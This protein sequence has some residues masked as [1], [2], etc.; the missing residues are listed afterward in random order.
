MPK[1]SE[2]TQALRRNRILDA[3]ERCFVR[4][5][6]NGATMQDIRREAGVSAG[7][8][9]VYFR[10]K[11]D[12]I[13]GISQRDR[14]QVRDNVALVAA[15]DD[16]VEGLAS[17][18]R[19]SAIERPLDKVRLFIE[20][21]AQ[22]N[23]SPAVARVL[24]EC[25]GDIRSALEET[26]AH[27]A[28]RDQIRPTMPISEL[29]QFMMMVVDGLFWRRCV[30]P[31]FDAAAMGPHILRMFGV[32]MGVEQLPSSP[33]PPERPHAPPAAQTH[34]HSEVAR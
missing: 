2:E 17:V 13:E 6:F 27:A 11:E 33:T 24:R 15:G 3:A 16:I 29:A 30:D 28:A 7:G 1:L 34:I 19:G 31:H 14:A 25:D 10:S 32:A 8:L 4:S 18:L 5:G 23:R 22:A 20:M 26:L 9:Y 21:G 12:L